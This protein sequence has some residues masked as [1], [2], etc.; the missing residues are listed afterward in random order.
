M[1]C[2][3]SVS[4]CIKLEDWPEGGYFFADKDK[5]E[6]G[7]PRGEVHIGGPMVSMGYII[8]PENPDPDV[9]EKNSS[10]YYSDGKGMRWFRSGATHSEKSAP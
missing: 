10:E 8:D 7:M 3:P 4:T 1:C 9:V 5:P 2:P 6:I